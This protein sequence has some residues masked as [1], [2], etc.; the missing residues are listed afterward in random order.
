MEQTQVFEDSLLFFTCLHSSFCK[1]WI[2]SCSCEG[3]NN[4]DGVKTP[5]VRTF[6]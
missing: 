3:N 1:A 4:R 5:I 2:E 6:D